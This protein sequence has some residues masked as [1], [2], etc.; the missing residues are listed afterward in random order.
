MCQSSSSSSGGAGK[1]P[2][3]PLPVATMHEH[4]VF[5]CGALKNVSNDAANQRT[6][7][8]IGGLAVLAQVLEQAAQ[9][10]GA[11]GGARG[12]A[13]PLREGAGA[14]GDHPVG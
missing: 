12:A 14:A 5:M 11:G 7:V 8:R 2:A 6:L 9:Q 4:L 10:V 13:K 3:Q 1:A